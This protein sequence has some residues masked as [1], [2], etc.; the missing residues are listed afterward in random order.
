MQIQNTFARI[1]SSF[2]CQNKRPLVALI[3]T[4]AQEQQ[5]HIISVKIHPQKAIEYFKTKVCPDHGKGFIVTTCKLWLITLL[6]LCSSSLVSC[7]S[8]LEKPIPPIKVQPQQIKFHSQ[9]TADLVWKSGII[10]PA[11]GGYEKKINIY[12][13]GKISQLSFMKSLRDNLSN[14][15]A[16]R[17]TRLSTK[18]PQLK[19]N[20]TVI[21]INFLKTSVGQTMDGL[22][23]HLTV[24]ITIHDSKGKFSRRTFVYTKS[25]N[26]FSRK[27]FRDQQIE[28]SQKLMYRVI[29]VINLREKLK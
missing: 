14:A 1:T 13:Y 25:A 28:A 11:N 12:Q 22:P 24:R 23:I 18:T 16:F 29:D 15:K 17:S 8:I 4:W 21:V 5:Q 20:H 19:T 2:M 27:T 6:V 10:M 3:Y 9:N 26:V 7:T